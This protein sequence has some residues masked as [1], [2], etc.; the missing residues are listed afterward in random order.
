MLRWN[1]LAVIAAAVAMIA[2]LVDNTLT[3]TCLFLLED[4]VYE[5]NPL[6]AH[7]M[8][9]WGIQ[10]T[11]IANA[12]WSAV[13]ITWFFLQTVERSSRLALLV[14][15]ALGLI[16]GFAALNNWYILEGALNWYILKGALS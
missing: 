16:R 10:L 8:E 9:H 2:V 11:M 3:A 1:I 12:A 14:L 7:L 4:T 13:V 15:V 5:T 6:S